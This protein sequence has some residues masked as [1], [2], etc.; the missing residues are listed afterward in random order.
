[1]LASVAGNEMEHP[2]N[3]A[4]QIDLPLRAAKSPVLS[5]MQMLLTKFAATP[6]GRDWMSWNDI[7]LPGLW[8]VMEVG[9]K[10]DKSMKSEKCK[11]RRLVFVSISKAVSIGVSV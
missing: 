7:E 5:D 2:P 9:S 11:K 1:M 8:R 3:L 4:L 6:T 10:F